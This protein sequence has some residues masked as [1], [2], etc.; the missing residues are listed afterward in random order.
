MKLAQPYN[1]YS[2]PYWH[3]SEQVTY[4]AYMH[5]AYDPFA[6]VLLANDLMT[7]S[8]RKPIHGSNSKFVRFFLV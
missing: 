2:A 7:D 1:G 3:Y 8:D 5:I 6:R 4:H